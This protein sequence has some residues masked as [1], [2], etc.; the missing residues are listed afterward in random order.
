[1]QEVL[2]IKG[3]TPLMIVKDQYSTNIGLYAL[4]NKNLNSF[5]H[6]GFKRIMNKTKNTLVAHF[7][8]F[9][10]PNKRLQTEKLPL[11]QRETFLTKFYTIDSSP[12]IVTK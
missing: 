1:M 8:Y 3:T 2:D 10:I 6:R 5:G 9:E 11:S 12:L 7:V 4:K